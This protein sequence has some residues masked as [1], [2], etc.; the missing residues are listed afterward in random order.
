MP[1]AWKLEQ[2]EKL[3]SEEEVRDSSSW[4]GYWSG[5]KEADFTYVF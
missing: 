2:E 1:L 3:W 5:K 4:V